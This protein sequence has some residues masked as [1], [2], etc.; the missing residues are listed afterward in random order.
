MMEREKHEVWVNIAKSVAIMGVL[1]DHTY[2]LLYTDIEIK[3]LSYY[4]V[5]L[6][7]LLAGYT[8]YIS[9]SKVNGGKVYLTIMKKV[10]NLLIPYMVATLLYYLVR[11]RLELYKYFLELIQF[12]AIGPFYFV[13]LYLQLI[14]IAPV[15]YR[16]LMWIEYRRWAFGLQII[17]F[18]ILFS[19]ANFAE[20]RTRT[21]SENLY[22]GGGVLF[23]GAYILLFYIGMFFKHHSAI[24]EK[25]NSFIG[26][27]F[28]FC[29]SL[30][31]YIFVFGKE[32]NLIDQ[33]CTLG[34]T[35]NV[36]VSRIIWTIFITF[37][38]YYAI[39]FITK[40]R[41]H[42]LFHFVIFGISFIGKHTLDIFL[43]HYLLICYYLE[44]NCLFDNIW[45]RRGWFFAVMILG[46]IL[47]GKFANAIIMFLKETYFSEW[48]SFR[49]NNG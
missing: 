15:L 36:S 17:M 22:G 14:L 27:L 43:Y 30:F 20:N 5:P 23:G 25:I 16:I 1:I 10:I 34:E 3:R 24:L 37:F 11:G 18:G 12:N 2:N 6:F 8:F 31:W 13:F 47:I 46:S 44:K 40:Y 7:I 41:I 39:S 48:S 33:Y 21:I 49:E 29:A 4:S 26:T 38:V 35:T 42:K 28:F 9:I 19:L 45:M 32:E